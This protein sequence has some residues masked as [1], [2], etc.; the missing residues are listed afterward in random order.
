MF[1]E[2]HFLRPLWLL[3]FVPMTAF[4]I[5]FARRRFALL[6]WQNIVEP[7]LMPHVLIGTDYRARRRIT[8]VLALAGALLI[9]A[10]AGPAWQRQPQPV[11]RSQ[12]ALVIA[13]DLS[14]SMDV[15]DINP[16][17]LARARFKIN[18]ILVRRTE[19]QT[20]L[21]VYAT[22]PFVVSPLTDDNRTI[23]S[24]LPALTTD[25]MPSQGSHADRAL[26]KAAELLRQAS[27]AEGEI[28][29]VSDGVDLDRAAEKAAELLDAGIRTSVLG[30]GTPDGGPIP[31]PGGFVKRGDGSIVISK[32]DA[33]S[34]GGVASAG[35]GAFRRL[36]ADET[37]IDQLLTGI[38]SR[39]EKGDDTGLDVD[40]WREEGPW[41]LL[42]LL[43]L[44]ALAFRRGVLAALLLVCLAPIRPAE[45]FDW[46]D[47]WSRPDQRAS[48]LFEEGN[49]ADAA[50]LFADRAWKGAA[51]HEAGHYE[52]SLAALE[53][54]DDVESTYNRGNSLARLGRY[55][56]AIAAYNDVLERQPEH[57]DARYNRDLLLE[58]QQ[59][60]QQSE[61]SSDQESR[62]KQASEDSQTD[63]EKDSGQQ[64][65]QQLADAQSS[66]EESQ[67]TG[68]GQEQA[69]PDDADP[70][71]ESESSAEQENEQLAESEPQP[72]EQLSEQPGE[73]QEVPLA[74]NPVTDEDAQAT[75]QWL[76]RIPDDPGGLLRRKF[77]YQYQQRGDRQRED[78]P[79]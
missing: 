20:A 64:H 45:A 35:G 23:I 7:Q 32:L 12:D 28:L 22:E 71:S 60:Q 78:E 76:R 8:L 36:S 63:Q 73:P 66:A 4:L 6:R 33:D 68:S 11:F 19:G 26:E 49:A 53:G 38:A 57:N 13:L 67:Q 1:E 77:L 74:D 69:E 75:E 56:E 3:A 70:A 40:I 2:F 52:D 15:A 61:S 42:P 54:L 18:D 24:Q 48:R 47:L 65:E 37:D 55:D 14:R 50:Q 79:W 21:I 46:A 59:Q 5:W 25:L 44:A 39:F 62:E 17:R 41:L 10:L 16:S 29:L 51:A 72:R 34:L 31:G 27:V 30:V 58:Q 9:L 43:P